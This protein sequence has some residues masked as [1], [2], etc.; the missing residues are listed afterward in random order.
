M[1]AV[2]LIESPQEVLRG[3]INVV[4]SRV[5]REVVREWRFGQF[6][7]EEIDFVQEEDD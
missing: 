3:A 7:S 2:D 1:R 6:G 5:I 4:A